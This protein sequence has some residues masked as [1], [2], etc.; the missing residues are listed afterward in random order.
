M[1]TPSELAEYVKVMRQEGVLRFKCGDLDIVLG[2]QAAPDMRPAGPGQ[3]DYNALLFAAT[4]GI[5]Y[6]EESD[7]PGAGEAD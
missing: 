7:G 5:G 1:I 4:E 6:G 2:P 3:D